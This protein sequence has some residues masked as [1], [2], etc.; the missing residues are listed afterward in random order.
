MIFVSR[1]IMLTL[2][3]SC[4]SISANFCMHTGEAKDDAKM[5]FYPTICSYLEADA[6]N[7]LKRLAIQLDKLGISI[8]DFPITILGDT[9][10]HFAIRYE[11]IKC[12]KML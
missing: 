12:L 4:F 5:I 9:A 6:A 11:K 8:M 1:K 10:P 2:F 7:D 3:L